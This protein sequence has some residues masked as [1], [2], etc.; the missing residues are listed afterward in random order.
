M[1]FS[2]PKC[3]YHHPGTITSLLAHFM[4]ENGGTL[5]YAVEMVDE[6]ETAKIVGLAPSTLKNMRYGRCP[7]RYFKQ[8]RSI[9]YRLD[10]L[11]LYALE[12]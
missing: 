3:G 2:C 7:I 5:S 8:G 12:K 4:A 1:R 10:D 11:L 9:R 6:K